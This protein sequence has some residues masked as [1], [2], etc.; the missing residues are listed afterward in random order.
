MVVIFSATQKAKQ[1]T[2][3]IAAGITQPDLIFGRSKSKKVIGFSY[4]K[5]II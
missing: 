1:K 2:S 4:P 3:K 5:K